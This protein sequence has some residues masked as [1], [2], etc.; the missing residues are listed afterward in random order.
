MDDKKTDNMFHLTIDI[1]FYTPAL[2]LSTQ[3]FLYMRGN[4]LLDRLTLRSL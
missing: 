1:R 2:I 4:V 3:N